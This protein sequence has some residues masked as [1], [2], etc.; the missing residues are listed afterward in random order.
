M[1]PEK[2]LKLKNL[3]E[4]RSLAINETDEGGKI[5]NLDFAKNC[6]LCLNAQDFYKN[7]Q[8]RPDTNS[9]QKRYDMLCYVIC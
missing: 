4:N 6:D 3:S 1:R 8:C 7:L 5:V 2:G 9:Y